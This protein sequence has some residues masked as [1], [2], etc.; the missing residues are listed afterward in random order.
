MSKI[1]NMVAPTR[2]GQTLPPAREAV[3]TILDEAD[4]IK[5]AKDC[6]SLSD[7]IP[8]RSDLEKALLEELKTLQKDFPK[9][10]ILIGTGL[11]ANQ[12]KDIAA[13]L[14]EG[15]H[16]IV[17]RDWLEQ[18]TSSAE[19]FEQGKQILRQVISGISKDDG[20]FSALG[21][22]IDPEGVRVWHAKSDDEPSPLET[23]Q[24]EYE[25]M[26]KML[27]KMKEETKK[28]NDPNNKPF[29]VK[30]SN[31]AYSVSRVY[32]RLASASSK[33]QVQ[34]AM[35]E[36]RRNIGTLRIAA[37]QG[38]TKEKNKARAAMGSLQKALLRGSR[39]IRRLNEEDLA[40]VRKKR[41]EKKEQEL[42][43]RIELQKKK[44]ARRSA[45][46]AIALEGHL[47]DVNNAFRFRKLHKDDEREECTIYSAYPTAAAAPVAPPTPISVPAGEIAAAD[48]VVSEVMA[49]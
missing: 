37:S 39:K 35:S 34:A 23:L 4:S 29:K 36:A 16:V 3:P 5:V 40:R 18:I 38:T 41:A 9:V 10:Q 24:K 32:S 14:G 33:S 48:V 49:F 47:D 45:D 21:A 44:S 15:K 42:R 19:A 31:S 22:Y 2:T 26:T 7:G 46:R 28:A 13:S 20:N 11:N 6:L 17:S 43:L 1:T 25:N 8:S 12:L 27:E 30:V